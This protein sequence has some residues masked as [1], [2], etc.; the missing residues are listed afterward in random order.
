LPDCGASEQKR[1]D[2]DANT[3][4]ADGRFL[5]LTAKKEHHGRAE[6]RQERNQPDVF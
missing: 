4:R 5:K 6:S 2:Y 3:Y 1:Q